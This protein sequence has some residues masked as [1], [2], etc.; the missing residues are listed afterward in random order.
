MP[1]TTVDVDPATVGLDDLADVYTDDST[2]QVP[3]NAVAPFAVATL[4][5][6]SNGV[7]EYTVGFLPAGDYTLAFACDTA[8]DDPVEYDGLTI[9]LPGDQRD[10]VTL[11]EGEAGFC[12]LPT[13]GGC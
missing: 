9:P 13:D 11:D 2:A 3:T 10:E 5:Q 6:R 7:W 8:D 12:D 1:D 4:D